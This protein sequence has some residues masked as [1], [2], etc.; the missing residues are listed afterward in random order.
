M[1]YSI[2][3]D[4]FSLF[5]HKIKATAFDNVGNSVSNEMYIWKFF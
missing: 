4:Q 1:E 2:I 3:W 5:K